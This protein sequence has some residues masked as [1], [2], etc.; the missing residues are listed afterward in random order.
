MPLAKAA[1]VN[2]GSTVQNLRPNTA[3]FSELEKSC[4]TKSSFTVFVGNFVDDLCR[5]S[6]FSTKFPTKTS[7]AYY[8]DSVQLAAVALVPLPREGGNCLVNFSII[9]PIIEGNER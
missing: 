1:Q 7:A 2:I 4:C 5:N 8:C 6:P 3:F 9:L